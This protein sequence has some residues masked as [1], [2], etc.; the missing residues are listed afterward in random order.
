MRNKG[1]IVYLV[2]VATGYI[3]AELGNSIAIHNFKTEVQKNDI[4]N[5]VVKP[6]QESMRNNCNQ[7]NFE[8]GTVLRE[9]SEKKDQILKQYACTPQE[10]QCKPSKPYDLEN[11]EYKVEFRYK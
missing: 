6:L 3:G 9:I 10:W 8:R 11:S 7:T 1:I 5:L 4:C 2:G